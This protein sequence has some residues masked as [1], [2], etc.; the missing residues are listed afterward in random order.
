MPDANL[1]WRCLLGILFLAAAA[2]AQE[3]NPP[4]TV[5]LAAPEPARE[6]GPET[7][8]SASPSDTLAPVP[9]V[10][11]EDACPLCL[12]QHDGRC[13]GRLA[14][15]RLHSWWVCSMKPR[16]QESHWGYPEEFC[17]QPLGASLRAHMQIQILHG[18]TARLALYRY[19]F[20]E[21][22]L[23]EPFKLNRHGR[24][25]LERLIT[26]MLQKN[27]YPLVIEPTPD[28]PDLDA[29]RRA[30]V[31]KELA[32]STFEV[33]EEWVVIG[34]PEPAGLSGDEALEVYQDLLR[35]MQLGAGAAAGG[36]AAP[37][38]MGAALARPEPQGQ[39]GGGY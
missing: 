2:V 7:A 9:E 8:P 11:G 25:R 19:D 32:A 18:M 4:S 14:G 27:L 1:A 12:Q 26:E 33:P 15:G 34:E 3:P 17:E 16:L 38:G 10:A 28:H 5:T 22:I 30:Y 29:A 13:A 23:D 6:P 39:S 21:G 20:H 31:L 36:T 37:A 24:R 35:Q